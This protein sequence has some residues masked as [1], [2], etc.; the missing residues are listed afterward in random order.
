M[1][2]GPGTSASPRTQLRV[3]LVEDCADDAQLILDALRHSGFDPSCQRVETEREYLAHLTPDLDVIL[4]DL[5]LPQFDGLRALELANDRGFDTPFIIVSDTIGEE[6]AVAAMQAGAYDYLLKDRLARLGPAVRR[7][8]EAAALRESGAH[9]RLAEHSNAVRNAAILDMALDGIFI[10]DAANTITEFNHAA[11]QMFGRIRADM[12][13]R[14]IDDVLQPTQPATSA[15]AFTHG[16]TGGARHRVE[17]TAQ[18]ADGR[19]FPV[20]LT[21]T[22]VSLPGRAHFAGL[23]RDV[24][25]RKSHEAATLERNRLSAFARDVGIAFTEAVSLKAMLELCVQLMVAQLGA[26]LAQIWT[27][28][29][30]EDRLELLASAG[31][32]SSEADSDGSAPARFFELDEVVRKR[33]MI[34]TNALID[35]SRADRDWA[36]ANGVVSFVGYPL[37]AGERVVGV[38]AMFGRAPFSEATVQA[39][40][41]IA[42][43]VASAIE[44]DRSEAS[45]ARLAAIVEATTDL[46]SI[47]ML[48]YSGVAY[49]N[50]AGRAMLGLDPQEA[51]PDLAAFRTGASLQE[52]TDLILPTALRDGLW[53]G[54]TTFVRRDGRLIPVSQLLLAHATEDGKIQLSTIARDVTELRRAAEALRTSDERMRFALEAARMG[55]WELNLSTQGVTWSE[56]TAWDHDEP[57]RVGGSEE[58]FFAATHVDDRDAVRQAIE[59]AIAGRQ[60]LAIVFRTVGP[61]GDTRWIE[62]RGR[63]IGDA[64]DAT[65]TRIVGVS[66]DVT[67]RKLL[68]AQLRQAQ[69]MEAIGQLAGGVAHDFNNLLTAILGY[70]KFAA[71]SLPVGDQRRHDVEEVIK[72]AKRAAGLTQQLLA[73]SRTQVLQS[74]LVDVNVLVTG[75]TDMLRRLIGEHIAL[76]LVLDPTLALVQAD[77]GQLEQV[78]MNLVVNARDSM[79]QG[80]RLTIET[81]NV[82]LDAASGLPNQVVLTGGYVMLTVADNGMGMD[83][84]TKRHLFEPFF[85]TKERGKGTGL[86]LATVY[87]IV[88]QSDGYIWVDSEPGQGSTFRV[89]LPRTEVQVETA[90]APAVPVSRHLGSETVLLVEDEAGVRG[91]ARRMLERAGY[92]VLDAAS[93]QDA[94]LIFAEHHGSIDLLI[95]D[96]IMP[97]LSGPDL[98]RRLAVEQPGLKVV[99]ISGYATEEMARQVKLDGRPHVQKPFTADQLVSY[100]RSILD[101]RPSPELKGAA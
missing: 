21:L 84:T 53:A 66:T 22:R 49:M 93:G 16:A 83:E 95:T 42:N 47:R 35:D 9:A 7:A 32:A 46:V 71:D 31:H 94:E 2:P 52:W 14:P 99:Y 45:Q 43:A 88:K 30:P 4:A 1:P 91:L 57:G 60:D 68:E 87:G 80:G 81:A 72:A 89:Y 73:F 34:A 24:S 54:E 37:I 100:V 29:P 44:R 25:E 75:I 59:H 18:H 56:M 27:P 13:G 48:D 17:M 62:C 70:A 50:Q 6:R 67:D 15:G 96:V 101:G 97:G 85:T 40:A 38:V 79:E 26:V 39:M 5:S 92:R 63:V 28:H 36:A 58:A 20:E 69:K 86:G 65:R 11:E 8:L 33:S 90:A 61:G 74:T 41:Y 98:F 77:A 64:A 55:V 51:L 78:V 76:D 19:R 12:I 82:Q 10:I 3:L 23:L